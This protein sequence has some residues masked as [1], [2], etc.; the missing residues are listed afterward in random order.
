LAHALAQG[1]HQI[2]ATHVAGIP[3]VVVMHVDDRLAAGVA[4]DER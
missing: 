4:T 2:T 3:F 1:Q